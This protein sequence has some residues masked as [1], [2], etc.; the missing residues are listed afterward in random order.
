LKYSGVNVEDETEKKNRKEKMAKNFGP[1][2]DLCVSSDVPEGT[3][4][5]V[6]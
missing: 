5:D 4:N 2:L 6:V 1:F 3:S